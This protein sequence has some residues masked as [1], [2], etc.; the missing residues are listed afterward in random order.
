MGQKSRVNFQSVILIPILYIYIFNPVFIIPGFGLNNILLLIAGIYCVINSKEF[1]SDIALYR[2][3]LLLIV[4]MIL[5]LFVSVSLT[6]GGY[7]EGITALF[8]F[9]TTLLFLPIFIVHTLLKKERKKGFFNILI[10]V[11]L[12]GAAISILCLLFPD[13]NMFIRGIQSGVEMESVDELGLSL[14]RS[15]G[16]GGNLTSAYGYMMG[17]L[18]ALCLLIMSR[19]NKSFFL[20]YS[21][22]FFVAAIINARTGV[23]PFF[24]TLAI[25]FVRS[26]KRFNIK[27]LLVIGFVAIAGFF[28]LNLLEKKNPDMYDYIYAF[29]EFFSSSENFNESSY[30]RMW[31]LPESIQGLIF[32]EGRNVFGIGDNPNSFVGTTSDIGFIRNV[33]LGGIIFLFLLLIEQFTLYKNMFK[34]SGKE[35]FVIILG[36][37]VLI[38]HY[39]G[40]LCY[41]TTAVSRF[42]LLYYFV[43]VY[44]TRNKNNPI[45][46][47]R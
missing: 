23:F 10:S 3:E 13:F 47:L 45:I 9:F 24:I 20:L 29:I 27:Y 5:Y 37:S 21:L 1:F 17:L 22:V 31:F 40:N 33:F 7:Y 39:K 42:V 18:S 19:E 16:L 32:G 43:L 46:M 28:V 6:G 35:L 8:G 38:F 4:V 44:N 25:I 14:L 11:G 30:S 12:I 26:L 36:L 41:I 34:R 15:F 2:K